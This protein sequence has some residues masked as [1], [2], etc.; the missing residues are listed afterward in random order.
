VWIA[1]AVGA[2]VKLIW[3]REGICSMTFIGQPLQFV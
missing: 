1:R 3:S 2:P